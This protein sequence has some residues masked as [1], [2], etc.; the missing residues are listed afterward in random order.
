MFQVKYNVNILYTKY[1]WLSGHLGT[2]GTIIG[3]LGIP[4][5]TIPRSS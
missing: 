2:Y 4:Y 3:V 1:V 5:T